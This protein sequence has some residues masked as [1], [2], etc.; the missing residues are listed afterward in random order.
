MNPAEPL[1]ALG[2]GQL[3]AAA[4]GRRAARNLENWCH[5]PQGA[6][7]LGQHNTGANNGHTHAQLAQ[8]CGGFFPLPTDDRHEVGAGGRS[9]VQ[10]FV[11]VRPV[12][13]D[14]RGLN[15]RFGSVFGVCDGRG[16][17]LRGEHATV[18]NLVLDGRIPA[19]GEEI[20]ARQV[21]DGVAPFQAHLPG[22]R[23]GR[24][25]L[26]D[27]NALHGTGPTDFVG[28]AG[29]NHRLVATGHQSF[30]NLTTDQAAAAGYKDF[31]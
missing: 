1:L 6:F 23:H 10:F 26:D 17:V 15:Q 19:L 8:A 21:D 27:L 13:A 7:T 28:P 24:V 31:H 16:D 9:F 3:A 5:G 4:H 14:G 30:H 12:K 18:T 22:T 11:T 25:A 29:K 2:R 20:M